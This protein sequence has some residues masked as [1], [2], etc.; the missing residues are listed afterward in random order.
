[1]GQNLHP[2]IRGG[3]LFLWGRT[4]PTV[5]DLGSWNLDIYPAQ[6]SRL[7]I[8]KIIWNWSKGPGQEHIGK[9]EPCRLSGTDKYIMSELEL[10]AMSGRHFWLN[11][12][13]KFLFCVPLILDHMIMNS[14]HVFDRVC[15]LNHQSRNLATRFRNFPKCYVVLCLQTYNKL[16]GW[17]PTHN[18]NS[19]QIRINS[20]V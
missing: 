13:P 4:P 6:I 12:V 20:C 7:H 10:R 5:L 14:H 9:S 16:I 3:I 15:L 19:T 17:V 1:M 11:L 8:V 18:S 2:Y